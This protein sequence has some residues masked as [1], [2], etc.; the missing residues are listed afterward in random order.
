MLHHIHHLL[1]RR[2]TI[3]IQ[4]IFIQNIADESSDS[5]PEQ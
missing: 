2:R 1:G 4:S 5:E 3:G